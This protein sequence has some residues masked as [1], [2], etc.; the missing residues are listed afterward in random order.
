MTSNPAEEGEGRRTIS[1]KQV[2]EGS[3]PVF[4]NLHMECIKSVLFTW[5]KIEKAEE[6]RQKKLNICPH[7]I[8]LTN[9]Q[10]INHHSKK[11]K[12]SNPHVHYLING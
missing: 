8:Q 7:K 6:L 2:N 3:V 1:G 4:L 10:C 11:K 9:A 5:I 12:K